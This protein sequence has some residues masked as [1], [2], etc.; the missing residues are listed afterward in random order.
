MRELKFRAW[1]GLNK[2]MFYDVFFDSLEVWHWDEYEDYEVLGDRNEGG[3]LIYMPIMQYAGLKDR[4]GQDI[5]EGD[6][7][8][9]SSMVYEIIFEQGDFQ[10]GFKKKSGDSLTDIGKDFS[11]K[12]E[13]I[14]N[15]YE[16]PEPE[17]LTPT[18]LG[19]E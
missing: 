19:G 2:I 8:K 16:K 4:A 3:A 17:K 15:I 18:K 5:Y 10:T 1:D 11:G 13:I 14:G 6:F 7:I 12:F 9:I